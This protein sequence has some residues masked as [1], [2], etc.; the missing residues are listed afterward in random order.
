MDYR[1]CSTSVASHYRIM[2]PPVVR[3]ITINVV[4]NID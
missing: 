1:A 4:T 2:H 3:K